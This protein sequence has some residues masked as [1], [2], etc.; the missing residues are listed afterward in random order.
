MFYVKNVPVLERVLRV[1]LGVGVAGAAMYLLG[2]L[3][4]MLVAG[5]AL[6]IALTGLFGFCPMCAMV[7]RRLDQPGDQQ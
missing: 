4:G 2:G 6:G 7:G 3:T 1:A 5:S